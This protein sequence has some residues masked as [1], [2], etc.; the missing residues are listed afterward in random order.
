MKSNLL[1]GSNRRGTNDRRYRAGGKRLHVRSAPA[2]V[3][4]VLLLTC[5]TACQHPTSASRQPAGAPQ[6]APYTSNR[7]SEGD[8]IKVAFEGDTNMTTTVK[9]QLDGT[10]NL[11]LVGV[12][13]AAGLTPDELRADLMQ[14]YKSLLSVNEITVTVV[15]ASASDYVSGAVLKPGRIPMDRPL[16]ALEAII[17]AGGFVPNKAKTWAV[18]VTRIENG[19]QQHFDL[20]LK[21]ALQGQD[22]KPFYLKPSDIIHVPEK[23]FTF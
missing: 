17:E 20:D 1:S 21:R 23:T 8:T 7:L 19:M 3:V 16:T 22:P 9:V 6:A 15:S 5:L 13:K 2:T 4:L 12:V 18:S 10:I 11:S 14:R